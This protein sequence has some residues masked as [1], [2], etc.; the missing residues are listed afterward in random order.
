MPAPTGLTQK[1][2]RQYMAKTFA[3]TQMAMSKTVDQLSLARRTAVPFASTWEGSSISE[4]GPIP[5]D[6]HLIPSKHVIVK[7]ELPSFKI[8]A[9]DREANKLGGKPWASYVTPQPPVFNE[10]SSSGDAVA[11]PEKPKRV[12]DEE[13][14]RAQYQEWTLQK[15]AFNPDIAAAMRT[16]VRK[17]ASLTMV[18]PESSQDPARSSENVKAALSDSQIT[19]P[20]FPKPKGYVKHF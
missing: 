5:T 16:N 10:P 19:G 8:M 7:P 4:H 12:M 3:D 18:D 20:A 14:W 6:A 2:K 11:P 17:Q 1:E 15:N 9:S 13:M